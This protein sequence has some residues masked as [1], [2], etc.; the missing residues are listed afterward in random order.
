MCGILGS[1]TN[2]N[3]NIDTF[4]LA[5]NKLSHRGPDDFGT[6]IIDTNN[7]R[8]ILGHRRLSI[9]DLTS[10]GHQPMNS[11]D[12][13]YTIVYNGEIY[14]YKEIRNEL[15]NSG[16]I[17]YT[18]T[19]TEV[20]L[21]AWTKW[22]LDC[23]YKF[24]GMFSFAIYD[25]FENC[26]TCVRDQFGIKPLFYYFN[27][28][29]LIF[30][31]EIDS[32]TTIKPEC[33]T[34]ELQNSYDYLT[35]GGYDEKNTTFYNG[36][37]QLKPAHYIKINLNNFKETICNWW[38]PNICENKQITFNEA[39]EELRT[40]F[41]E[42]ISY[43][44]RSDVPVGITLSGGIDSSAIACAIR[45]LNPKAE[46]NT[47]SYIAKNSVHSEEKW[48]DNINKH[49][50]AIGHKIIIEPED[51]ITDLDDLINCQ[52][53]PFGST[54]IYA[55]YR[56]YKL[57]SENNIVVTL[58]GQGADELLAGYSG[59]PSYRVRSLIDKNDFIG[60]YKFLKNWSKWPGRSMNR[61]LQE[62][63]Y[64]ILPT[65]LRS[66]LLQLTNN[67][68]RLDWFNSKHFMNTNV[69]T[70]YGTRQINTK[71]IRERRLVNQL[72]R[73]LLGHGLNSLLRHGDRNSM[74]WTIEGRVP[75]LS[76]KIAEFVLQL[77]ENFLISN[78][79]ETKYIFKE[80]L[81]GIVPDM[82]LDRRDKVG[83][84]TPELTWLKKM[85]KKLIKY[86]DIAEEIPFLNVDKC[87]LEFTS[88]INGEKKFSTEIWRLINYCRWAQLK[89][90][91][92]KN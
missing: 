60:A 63:L 70:I 27:E 72:R 90:I 55:Q 52:G 20:L 51:I 32:I 9:I 78:R 76:P 66:N 8:L 44:L 47:F 73:R 36:I 37:K 35:W 40:L 14:N 49:I 67:E 68:F 83:F 69:D 65:S 7:G 29:T 77:P 24:N 11:L 41:L 59:F 10:R 30:S 64:E 50:G 6:K 56:V 62:V 86:L 80:A 43:N 61:G 42:N 22:N 21:T 12:L 79:G 58:D 31:S 82:I 39:K 74:K 48:V 89:N 1:F 13:R 23:I 85:D 4:N 18:E 19:D 75:F 34:I 84:V 81:R 46:I 57:A 54:S 92:F 25:H 26:I 33:N 2:L 3:N 16:H 28:K 17:F 45:Y 87:R 71:D 53:E 91:K 38:R 15:I 5:L 88:I